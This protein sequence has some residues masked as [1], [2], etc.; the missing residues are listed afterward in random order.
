MIQ[1]RA[2][3]DD[4]GT[5]KNSEAVVIGEL[6]G[7]AEQWDRFERAWAAKLAQPLPGKPPLSKFHLA[8]CN[9]KAGEFVSYS[10]AEQ[11]AVIHDF[12]R[13]II[14]A[15]LT[16]V[17][18]AIEKRAWD[19]L[20]VEPYSATLGSQADRP[21]IP[22]SEFPRPPLA[23]GRC[24]ENSIAQTIRIAIGPATPGAVISAVIDQGI[25][26][27]DTQKVVDGFGRPPWNSHMPDIDWAQ[28]TNSLPLQGADIVA[29]ES[30][31]HAIQVLR[32]GVGAQP[33]P[34]LRHYLDNMLAQGL[35][36]TRTEIA[37][38][39]RTNFDDQRRRRV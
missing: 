33:R 10:E 28:V 36:V 24:L 13:I 23:L 5:H 31:W 21:L 29:T 19:E 18:A 27:I 3:Y 7:S 17:A 39:L 2:A 6:I 26:N 20:V 9:S 25:R 30:Y 11:N 8:E 38:M 1:I 16:S 14:D 35:I 32:K 22:L 34:H 12:R 4:A 37:E 15:K